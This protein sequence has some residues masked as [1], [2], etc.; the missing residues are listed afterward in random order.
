[1]EVS[2]SS[3][4]RG[5]RIIIVGCGK[6]GVTLIDRLSK[7][8]HEIIVIDEDAEKVDSMTNLYDIMGIIGNGA[9]YNTQI[10]AGIQDT[11]LIIAVTESDELNLLCCT[12]AKQVGDCAAIARVRT[13][14]YN[15]ELSYLQ[16]KLGLAMIINPEFEAAREIASI[17]SLPSTLEVNSFAH[18]QAEMVEVQIEPNNMLDGMKIRDLSGKFSVACLIAAVKRGDEVHIP[19]GDFTLEADDIISVVGARHFARTF[20]H[21]IG[22]KTRQ[23]KDCLIVGGGKSSFYLASALLSNKINVRIIE[24]D[25]ARCEELSIAFPKA[26]IINGDGTDES[27]LREEGLEFAESFVPLTG[28][29]EENII[30]TLFANQIS[31]AKVVTKVNRINFDSVLSQ[32]NLGSVIYPKHITAEAIIAYVRAKSAS[33]EKN[34]ETLYHLFDQ[35]VEAIEF[36]ITEESK[37][38]GTALFSLQFKDNLLIAFINRNGKIIIPKGADTLEVGDTVMV[39]TTHTGFANITDTLR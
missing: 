13:P 3:A 30:L 8:G 6:V 9:S 11:D 35:K 20:L 28:L 29:D 32:L 24:R 7:E 31:N 10:E 4:K 25:K 34:I 5:L 12:I 2:V 23:V 22:I 17:L 26:T 14:D 19:S 38:T 1:M 37:A 18:G 39:V 16:E 36:N 27:L 21:E 33:N 15:K